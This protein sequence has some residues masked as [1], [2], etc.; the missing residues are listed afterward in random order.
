[1]ETAT[2]SFPL[3]TL[4]TTR[5]LRALAPFDYRLCQPLTADASRVTVSQSGKTK[6]TI[7]KNMTNIYQQEGWLAF[8]NGNGA[9]TLKIMPES[10]IR[11]AGYEVYKNWVCRVRK[12]IFNESGCRPWRV[13]LL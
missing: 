4:I 10:A 8:W 5:Q 3:E 7:V 1:M 12:A 6:G 9:N 13:L 2:P 11:F